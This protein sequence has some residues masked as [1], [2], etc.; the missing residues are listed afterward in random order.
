VAC[1]SIYDFVTK[2]IKNNYIVD[3]NFV[4]KIL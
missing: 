3:H 1:M 2:G 4:K